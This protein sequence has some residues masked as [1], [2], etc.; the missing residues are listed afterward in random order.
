M[1][2]YLGTDHR[3][4][5]LK[6]YVKGFLRELGYAVEDMGASKLD[7]N[8][9]YPDFAKAVAEKVNVGYENDKGILICGSGVGVTVVANKF[10]YVRA[11]L[12]SSPDQ[13]FDSRNDDDSNILCLAADYLEPEAARKIVFTWLQTAFAGGERFRRRLNKILQIEQEVCKPPQIEEGE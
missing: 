8:D 4:F 12:I 9:D 2:I 1:V 3:G 7:E 11:A 10:M 13:A 6:E 5:R